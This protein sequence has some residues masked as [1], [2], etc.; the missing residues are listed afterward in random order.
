MISHFLTYLR[1][2]SFHCSLY[3]FT[4][5][6]VTL[7]SYITHNFSLLVRFRCLH[8]L[9]FSLFTW[10]INFTLLLKLICF[11]SFLGILFFYKLSIPFQH[12]FTS[13]HTLWTFLF[14]L[15]YFIFFLIV[16]PLHYFIFNTLYY[17]LM[18]GCHCIFNGKVIIVLYPNGRA[19]I[20]LNYTLMGGLSCYWIIPQMGG[21]SYHWI[22]PQWEG[23]HTL[24]LSC[25]F[26]ENIFI[27]FFLYICHHTSPLMCIFNGKA[28]I[29]FIIPC[30]LVNFTYHHFLII[31]LLP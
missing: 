19:I 10:L 6:N 18:E 21:S 13:F 15:S 22:I 25:M 4:P 9:T 5:F 16:R 11:S 29:T 24:P 27:H 20:P 17:S 14:F 28:I 23:H 12:D 1:D 2:L 3:S 26:N 7:F 30:V 31:N 8:Y